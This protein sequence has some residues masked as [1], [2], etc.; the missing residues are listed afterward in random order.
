AALPRGEEECWGGAVIRTEEAA[1]EGPEAEAQAPALPRAAPD[2]RPIRAGQRVLDSGE[3]EVSAAA[4]VAVRLA[5]TG[6]PAGLA[7]AAE[8]EGLASLEALEAPAAPGAV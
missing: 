5:G 4:A 6:A 7:A 2:M 1:M 3:Q 8:V